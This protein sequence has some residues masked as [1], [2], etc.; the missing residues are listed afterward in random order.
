MKI[1]N[2][3]LCLTITCLL[4]LSVFAQSSNT[5]QKKSDNKKVENTLTKKAPK[6]C[7]VN[8]NNTV[9]DECNS[10]GVSIGYLWREIGG[11]Y[12]ADGYEAEYF[13]VPNIVAN[14]SNTDSADGAEAPYLEVID[15]TV[16]N[17]AYRRSQGSKDEKNF[18]AVLLKNYRKVKAEYELDER[19]WINAETDLSLITNTWDMYASF[20][21]YPFLIDPEYRNASEDVQK[22]VM[23]YYKE[24]YGPKDPQ[25]W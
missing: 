19:D 24:K 4:P 16:F 10:D 11:E 22:R 5:A 18:Q 3:A 12:T 7:K 9:E 1:K 21:K 14:A 25:L 23:D 20:D 15:D 8:K 2:L 13:S 17:E 6:V